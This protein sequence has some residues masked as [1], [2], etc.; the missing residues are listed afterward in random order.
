MK[1]YLEVKDLVCEAKYIAHQAFCGLIPCN[2]W[3]LSVVADADKALLS[4]EAILWWCTEGGVAV[5]L[6]LESNLSSALD[7]AY[8]KACTGIRFLQGREPM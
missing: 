5:D 7:L 2:P 3:G 8:A 1:S 6:A 4:A